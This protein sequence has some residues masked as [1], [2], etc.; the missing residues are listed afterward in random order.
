MLRRTVFV[1]VLF[2]TTQAWCEPQHMLEYLL[3]RG[4]ARGATV[5]VHL[6]GQYL[7]DPREIL[8]Y[9]AGIKAS[10]LTPG[11]KPAEE[12]GARFEIAADCPLGEHV[13][14]LRTATGLSEAVTFWVSPFPTVME[15]EKK[16]GDNDTIA[17]AQVVPMNSTVESQINPGDELDRDVYSV[18]AREGQRISV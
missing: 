15:V 17:K 5:E 3:P 18:A 12:V 2:L 1:F 14:R 16:I 4:G 10:M 11:A 13:L 8:F 7:N 9:S 6:H